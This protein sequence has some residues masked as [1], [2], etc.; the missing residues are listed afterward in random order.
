MTLNDLFLLSPEISLAALAG[1]LIVL[2]I[3]F[4]RKGF[5]PFVG[6]I[7]LVVPLYFSLQLWFHL[8]ATDASSLTGLFG[9]FEVDKFA[10]F[11]K[12][13]F[14]GVAAL[15]LLFSTEY[16][17]KFER[18]RG[19]FYSLILIAAIGMMLLAAT[20]EL[21]TIYI[22]LEL[23]TL[24]LAALAA[25]MRD[26]RSSESGM[27]FL[28]LGAISSAVLLYGMVMV[29]GFTGATSLDMIAARLGEISLDSGTAF[30]S[31]ALLFGIVLIIAGF[32]FKIS[33]VPFQ[34]WAPDVYEGAPTP[35][36]AFLSVASKAA[37]F[38]VILR[39]FYVAFEA[40]ALSLDWGM[41]FAVVSVLSMTWGN[42]V[43]IRQNNI[44]RLMAYSTIAQA[45]YILVGL[46]AVAARTPDADSL[47]GPSGVLFYLGGY[48]LTNLA[49]FSVVIAISNRIGSDSID[50]FAGMARRAPYLAGVLAFSLVSLTGVPPTVG[51][52]SK[53]YIFSAA[54]DTNLE[55]LALA[56]VLNSVISAYYYLRIIKVMYLAEPASEER[57]R[58]GFPIGLAITAA[59]A[60]TLF[61]GI[62][63]T[64]LIQ[65]ARMAAEVL[66]A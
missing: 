31:P 1:V 51:F 52:M 27:K 55:W 8:D 28:I 11:F 16:S 65:L 36:T 25:F 18:F 45:G 21:I 46:A 6:V 50:D 17:K 37:G 56:G 64:P 49:A 24:P 10:L 39:V 66:I 26:S 53:I 3:L 61:F 63:P 29:Y 41:I 9:T 59:A 23:T 13:L 7:G 54:V 48:A 35:V 20:K 30:G 40:Q 43:A 57:L 33:S 2:D 38:A 19:E 60:G 4:R 47:I 62:Y 42:L 5:L 12:F 22:S 58:F 14:I 34:M 44:K 15:T 32:G